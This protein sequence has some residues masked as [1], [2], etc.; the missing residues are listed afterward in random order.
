MPET[1]AIN[2]PSLLDAT[3]N[4]AAAVGIPLTITLQSRRGVPGPGHQIPET[5]RVQLLD[6]AVDLVVRHATAT[7]VTDVEWE[8]Y[9]EIGEHDWQAVLTRLDRLHPFPPS[10]QYYAACGFLAARAAVSD[11]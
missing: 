8:D 1:T 6:R 11:A 2:A 5:T 3:V 10:G 7:A 4:F 9:P